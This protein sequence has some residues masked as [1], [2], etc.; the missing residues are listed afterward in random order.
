MRRH[1]LRIALLVWS[2]GQI[3]VFSDTP[4][5][6]GGILLSAAGAKIVGANSSTPVAAKAS[7]LLF[8]GDSIQTGASPASYLFCA[9]KS[10]QTLAPKAEAIFDAS[11]VRVKKGKLA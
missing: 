4:E 11:Q 10:R 9:G 1:S 2:S 5:T 6:R 3:A 8:S 7:D